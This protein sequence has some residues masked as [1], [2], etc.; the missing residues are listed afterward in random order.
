VRADDTTEKAGLW[1]NLKAK[2]LRAHCFVAI[3]SGEHNANVMIEV[4]RMEAL[5]RPLLLLHSAD[6]PDL[7]SDLK[8]LLYEEMQAT[9][10]DLRREI[11]VV[12]TR[13]TLFQGLVGGDRYLSETML[14]RSGLQENASREISRLHP[15]WRGLLRADSATLARAVG[16]PQPMIEAAK[17]SLQALYDEG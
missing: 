6:A 2:L 4:G 3:L 16:L 5:E 7:P 13:H 17:Q 10:E 14:A 8:G 15:T 11:Q 1:D 12:L 9:G